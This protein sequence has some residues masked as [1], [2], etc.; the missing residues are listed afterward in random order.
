MLQFKPRLKTKHINVHPSISESEKAQSC[1]MRTPVDWCHPVPG[2]LGWDL[3]VNL[4]A[5][6]SIELK[7]NEIGN[8]IDC[9]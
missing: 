2:D 9:C 5:N 4:S 1:H 8:E 7:A 6:G 3:W